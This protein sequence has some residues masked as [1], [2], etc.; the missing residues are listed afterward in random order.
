LIVVLLVIGIMAFGGAAVTELASDNTQAQYNSAQPS[1]RSY[2]LQFNNAW[3]PEQYNVDGQ[4]SRA[5]T[6]SNQWQDQ[7]GGT[8]VTVPGGGRIDLDRAPALREQWNSLSAMEKRE[9]ACIM[10]GA[11]C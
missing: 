10:F 11:G 9:N 6:T 2:N 5:A 7:Q 8:W 3:R 4:R 1:T